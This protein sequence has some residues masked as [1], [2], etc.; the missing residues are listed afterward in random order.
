MKFNL[1]RIAAS[2][3]FAITLLFT[4][5]IVNDETDDAAPVNFSAENTTRAVQ[6]DNVVEGTLNIM[7][8]GFVENASS[9]APLR[10]ASYFPSCTTITVTINGDSGT[11]VLDFGT[12]CQLN[13]GNV[14]SG[15]IRLEFGPIINGTRTINYTFEDYTYNGNG[16]TG[17]GE[18]FR[19]IANQNGNPQSTVNESITVSFT[20]TTVTATRVGNRV[21]EWTEGVGTGTWIDNVYQVTG[22]WDTTFSNGF[23]RSGTV[24]QALVRKMNCAYLVSGVLEIEQEN[25][26]GI[27][28]WGNGDCDNQALFTVNGYE[29]P[30]ILGN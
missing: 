26:L 25:L 18:I 19:Q 3:C 29:F 2:S 12:S 27:I 24:T 17:G 16:V 23:Y 30:I 7:E 10:N 21:A 28:D 8:N 9:P 1:M 15:I 4:S 6:A 11:I 20:N 13:D 22:N 5:C 14:V